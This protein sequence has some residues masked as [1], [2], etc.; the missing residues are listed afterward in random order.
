MGYVIGVDGGNTK[1]IALVGTAD[2]T[3]VGSGR[4]G[5]SDIYGAV[6]AEAALEQLE[7]SID[8]ALDLAGISREAVDAAYFCLAGADWPEDY[9][10]LHAAVARWGFG[11][12]V[13]IGND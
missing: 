12:I 8:G 1:T 11:G 10:W 5:C 3:I 7:R 6:S 4:S 2:G 9:S 13:S